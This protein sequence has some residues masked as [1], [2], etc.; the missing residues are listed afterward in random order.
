MSEIKISK[1]EKYSNL[2]IVYELE[3]DDFIVNELL[4]S[5]ES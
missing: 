2:K 3:N 5:D 1:F 4:T